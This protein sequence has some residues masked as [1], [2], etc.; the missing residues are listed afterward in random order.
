MTKK[1]IVGTSQF[2]ADLNASKSVIH[3]DP[4]VVRGESEGVQ[5]DIAMQWNDS[6]DEAIYCFTN[7]IENRDGGAHLA[8]FR[9]ALTRTLGAYGRAAFWLKDLA[10][11]I[12]NDDARAF[13]R[14]PSGD[15][16]PDSAARP[17]DERDL[18]L[19]QHR[20]RAC[21]RKAGK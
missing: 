15:G 3:D 8:G 2:V 4:I 10:V 9:A 17:G 21:V 18:V 14:E 7:D 6:Y 5:V 19:E 16:A 20:V 1:L 11:E 13:A 12:G